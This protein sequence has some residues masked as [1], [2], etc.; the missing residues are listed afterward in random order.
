[1]VRIELYELDKKMSPGNNETDHSQ[2][3][4]PLRTLTL[5]PGGVYDD[6]VV[7]CIIP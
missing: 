4:C 7:L 1:M 3:E 6:W 2:A 5:F